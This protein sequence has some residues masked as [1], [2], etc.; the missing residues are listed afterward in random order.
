VTKNS[1]K[2]KRL[3]AATKN[4]MRQN[5]VRYTVRRSVKLVVRPRLVPRRK[6][7]SEI[8]ESDFEPVG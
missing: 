2:W 1:R 3:S 5:G 6:A 8:P 7:R 4:G